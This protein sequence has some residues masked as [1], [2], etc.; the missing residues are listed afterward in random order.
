MPNAGNT[1]PTY[2]EKLEQD[3]E[4]LKQTGLNGT[5]GKKLTAMFKAERKKAE[6]LKDMHEF[7][8]QQTENIRAAIE[9]LKKLG[10]GDTE[11]EDFIRDAEAEVRR[12]I[13]EDTQRLFGF[14]DQIRD[15]L[16]AG[17]SKGHEIA[18]TEVPTV[19]AG[20]S[21]ILNSLADAWAE[22][23]HRLTQLD[24]TKYD[25]QSPAQYTKLR[26]ELEA[27]MK[28]ADKTLEASPKRLE[29]LLNQKMKLVE[30]YIVT[31]RDQRSLLTREG[32]EGLV[33]VRVKPEQMAV[34]FS[35]PNEMRSLNDRPAFV[36]VSMGQ[37][38]FN[39]M[40]KWDD[41]NPADQGSVR[42]QIM[43]CRE[44]N[45]A[46]ITGVKIVPFD[47]LNKHAIEL[48]HKMTLRFEAE[49][50][51]PDTQVRFEVTGMSDNL[52]NVRVVCFKKVGNTPESIAFD[53]QASPVAANDVGDVKSAQWLF[54]NVFKG[55]DIDTMNLKID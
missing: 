19:L 12:A 7:E 35:D 28:E 49:G 8:R 44:E 31:L 45:N 39:Y 24:E 13:E 55:I 25:E 37:K 52:E 4:K 36:R 14:I 27:S 43:K 3:L 20:V 11:I 54:D 5:I 10:M 9:G 18:Q 15:N 21:P 41:M 6:Y 32:L 16:D 34:L 42:G 26:N 29:V 38:T 17:A 23:L 22:E 53:H 47:S 40:G 46:H 51:T 48:T 50:E 30:K 2:A 1:T 33:G